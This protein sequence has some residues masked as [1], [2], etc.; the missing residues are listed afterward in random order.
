MAS[1]VAGVTVHAKISTRINHICPVPERDS[2]APP[3]HA[4]TDLAAGA[5]AL[6]L[7]AP[8]LVVVLVGAVAAALGRLAGLP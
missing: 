7:Q 3:P 5:A 4:V 6:R 1:R 8:Y 2:V